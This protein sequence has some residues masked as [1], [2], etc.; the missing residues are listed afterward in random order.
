MQK[1]FFALAREIEFCGIRVEPSTVANGNGRSPNMDGSYIF[2][3]ATTQARSGLYIT[4]WILPSLEFFNTKAQWW[5]TSHRE[6]EWNDWSVCYLTDGSR[7]KV[8]IF[9]LICL[10]WNAL[11]TDGNTVCFR[12]PG[13]VSEL[14]HLSQEGRSPLQ[15][16]SDLSSSRCL[17]HPQFLP[18]IGNSNRTAFSL[19]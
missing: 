5:S 9:S 4:W 17:A 16:E 3:E 11:L 13:T 12:D 1:N 7:Y 10:G 14:S 2:P 6:P 8:I 18:Y 19:F 15:R